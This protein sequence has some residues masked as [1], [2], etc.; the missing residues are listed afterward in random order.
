LLSLDVAAIRALAVQEVGDF[1]RCQGFGGVDAQPLGKGWVHVPPGR[2]RRT[3]VVLAGTRPLGRAIKPF[4][5]VSSIIARPVMAGAAKRRAGRVPLHQPRG[6]E[7]AKRADRQFVPGERA[8]CGI[9][10]AFGQPIG[11]ARNQF[12]K[13][14][15]IIAAAERRDLN[16]VSCHKT[17]ALPR[18]REAA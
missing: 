5:G 11:L 8:A 6:H 3:A 1:G 7:G 18:L 15:A 14:F 2:G 12:V 10:A 17:E 9:R 4:A 13:P 16:L